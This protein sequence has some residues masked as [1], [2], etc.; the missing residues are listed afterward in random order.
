MLRPRSLPVGWYPGDAAG[1][2]AF[3][4]AATEESTNGSSV[5]VIAPHAGWRFSGHLAAGAIA[6]LCSEASTIVV[7]GGHLRP[8]DDVR[9]AQESG[10]ETP[11]GVIPSDT[12]IRDALRERGA[13]SDTVIDNTVEVHLPMVAHL[14]PGARVV[15]V[16]VPPDQ[17]A[18]ALGEF[19]AGLS[20]ELGKDIAVIG[21]TDLTHYGPSYRFEPA[22]G[23]LPGVRWAE[24]ND[25][26]FV[27]ALLE[28]EPI[29]AI[30]HAI[31]NRSACSSGAAAAAAAFAAARG[32]A[33]TILGSA[34]SYDVRPDDSH[35]GY[36]GITYAPAAQ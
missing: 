30:E 27:D 11:V 10:F 21:S 18:I 8:G 5:A 6:T 28:R 17:S 33:G 25:R 32:A 3:I 31:Q 4:D 13:S 20:S 36:A 24:Q 23:G 26:D 14:L 7:V 22:G 29:D 34:S 16:R 35:V 12:E 2:A 15:W 9:V 1:A 19:L